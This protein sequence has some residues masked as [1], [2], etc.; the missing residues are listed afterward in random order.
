MTGPGA[1]IRKEVDDLVLKITAYKCECCNRIY[2]NPSSA[3]SHW[4]R[5]YGNPKNRA[6]RTCKHCVET[7]EEI[8]DIH[9]EGFADE[10]DFF[11]CRKLNHPINHPLKIAKWEHCCKHYEYGQDNFKEVPI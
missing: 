3:R 5:C 6:C 10:I 7:S 1:I 4:S 8:Q 2:E 9:A 11:V